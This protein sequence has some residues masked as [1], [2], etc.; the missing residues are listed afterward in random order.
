MTS[1]FE[2]ISRTMRALRN[3]LDWAMEQRNKL[4]DDIIKK[5]NLN[6]RLWYLGIKLCHKLS[7]LATLTL[8]T[9]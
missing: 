4:A 6:L 7:I 3:A 8:L 9:I 1:S 5:E 2:S